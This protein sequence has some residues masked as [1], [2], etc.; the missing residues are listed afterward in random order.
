MGT[1]RTIFAHALFTPN[2]EQ[3]DQRRVDA[4]NG[5]RAPTLASTPRSAPVRAA[6]PPRRVASPPTPTLGQ[7]RAELDV[8]AVRVERV[9]ASQG[10]T[11]VSHTSEHAEQARTSERVREAMGLRPKASTT[12][13][14]EG[15]TLVLPSL[16]PGE[17][18]ALVQANARKPPTR[19]AM[20]PRA[21]AEE[22]AHAMGRRPDA[23]RAPT[24]ERGT[25]TLPSMT[26]KQAR[27]Y[28]ASKKAG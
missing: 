8:L 4:V 21:E 7:V 11:L 26:A 25:L 18:R 12:P 28:L 19:A 9:S 13:R 2:E 1:S 14:V 20:L 17:A 6:T 23:P 15:G 27:D 10:V 5:R 22:L 24:F 16:S 3:I